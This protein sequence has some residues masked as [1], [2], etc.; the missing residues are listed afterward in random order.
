[1][2]SDW[3]TLSVEQGEDATVVRIAGELDLAGA[4]ELEA[5][6]DQLSGPVVVDCQDLSFVDAAGIGVF[7]RAVRGNSDLVVRGVAPPV[8]RV[9]D[10]TG[11]LELVSSED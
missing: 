8:R 6:L 11:V 3:F 1:M 5:V 9:F 10:V 4:P 2:E 7:A